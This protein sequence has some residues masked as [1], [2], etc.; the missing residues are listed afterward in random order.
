M[1][2]GPNSS[3][4]CNLMEWNLL[5]TQLP[6]LVSGLNARPRAETNIPRIPKLNAQ[7]LSQSH[8]S[9]LASAHLPPIG[10]GYGYGY[11]VPPEPENQNRP[12]ATNVVTCGQPACGL[13]QAGWEGVVTCTAARPPLAC[14]AWRRAA[15]DQLQYVAYDVLMG[16]RGTL[17]ASGCAPSPGR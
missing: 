3:K 15:R 6:E 4:S 12:R 1:H 7:Q 17:Q 8:K 13:G 16:M 5:P 10:Y 11:G 14:A 2:V 9:S